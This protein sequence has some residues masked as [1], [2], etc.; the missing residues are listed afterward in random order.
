MGVG[1][2]EG[3]HIVLG[4]GLSGK[5]GTWVL[6]KNACCFRVAATEGKG[7]G[8]WLAHC[9]P[10]KSISSFGLVGCLFHGNVKSLNFIFI[11]GC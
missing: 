3:R 10:S 5:S 6:G 8:F 4:I 11:L 2:A 9:F 7:S 1:W